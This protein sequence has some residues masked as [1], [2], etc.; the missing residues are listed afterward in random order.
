M[1]WRLW[2]ALYKL[3]ELG[4]SRTVKTSTLEV[5]RELEVSQ[6]TASRHLIELDKAGYITKQA[7]REGLEVRLTNRGMEELR[8]VYVALKT[9]M[10]TSQGVT[11]IEGVV[12]SGFGEGAYYVRQEE[13]RR[14]FEE[15]IGFKPYLGTLNLKL[16]FSNITKKRELEAYPPILI[17]GFE[18][19]ERVFG[20]VR[21]YPTNINDQIAGAVILI[22]R[23][24]Y[25]ESVIEVIAPVH[26]R[27]KLNLMDGSK[28]T[29]KFSSNTLE[30]IT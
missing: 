5:A 13:Y 6:Q 15:K 1:K 2:F 4:A 12:F 18:T 7:S 3:L 25:D 30:K 29:L 21:C 27:S 16:T 24:H 8:K 19:K 14:Q 10:E 17:K 22:N 11:I 26:L 23:T 28:V 9:V 20:D